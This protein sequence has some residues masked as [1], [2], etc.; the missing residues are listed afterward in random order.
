MN[1]IMCNDFRND[2]VTRIWYDAFVDDESISPWSF[3]L[4]R[5]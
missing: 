2:S 4:L 1:S 3:M 5:V